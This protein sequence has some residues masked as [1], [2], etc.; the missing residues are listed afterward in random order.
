MNG[1]TLAPVSIAPPP[2]PLAVGEAVGAMFETLLGKALPEPLA[3]EAASVPVLTTPP[4]PPPVDP[5]AAAMHFAC[6]APVETA[7]ATKAEAPSEEASEPPAPAPA[8]FA[9]Q[10]M[11]REL[12]A[13]PVP[14]PVSST[15]TP[16]DPA[17]AI[18][19][20]S[21]P[22]RP[23]C[24]PPAAPPKTGVSLA[25]PD[26]SPDTTRLA[27]PTPV[28]AVSVEPA[29]DR[30]T[31]PL[32]V[33]P[34]ANPAAPVPLERSQAAL[35]GARPVAVSPREPGWTFEVAR[36][37]VANAADPSR[38]VFRL[39]PEALGSMRVDLTA[40]DEGFAV[41]ITVERDEARVIV[42][43][44]ETRLTD[45]L[46]ANGLRVVETSVAHEPPRDRQSSGQPPP[47]PPPVSPAVSHL[48]RAATLKIR[49][50]LEGRFA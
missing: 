43:A 3:I 23:V 15:A 39:Q 11:F 47:A 8:T 45:D 5:V 46:R 25:V 24:D 22:A 38:V 50:R 2:L 49:P 26:I 4:P 6:P 41:A 20:P 18:S 9:I 1:L 30:P 44:A 7:D 29:A 42:A 21:A 14:L 16:P 19:R 12:P 34:V 40:K 13:V 37:I 10:V 28:T 17:P 33:P 32:D 48:R 27:L 31:M 36:Q 35:V